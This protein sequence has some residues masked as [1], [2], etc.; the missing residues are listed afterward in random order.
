MLIWQISFVNCSV[1]R[2][3]RVPI[4][5]LFNY[6]DEALS[7]IIGFVHFGEPLEDSV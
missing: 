4:L 1:H 5:V 7:W 6:I 2:A 3:S